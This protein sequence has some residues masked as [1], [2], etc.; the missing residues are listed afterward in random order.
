MIKRKIKLINIDVSITLEASIF[1][2]KND[3]SKCV[4]ELHI[5]KFSIKKTFV[6][7]DYFIALAQLRNWL[8]GWGSYYPMCKGVLINVYPSRMSRQMSNGIKAYFLT[9]GKQAIEDDLVDI[10]DSIDDG[11]INRIATPNKQIQYFKDWIKS[12]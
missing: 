2:Y 1:L 12:L 4:I 9:L 11:E 7:D 5:L 8:Y 3:Y 6:S 10:F